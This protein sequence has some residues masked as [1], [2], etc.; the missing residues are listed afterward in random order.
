MCAVSA[1]VL[2]Q[3][4]FESPSSFAT[5]GDKRFR[6]VGDGGNGLKNSSGLTNSSGGVHSA[7]I[8]LRQLPFLLGISLNR[9]WMNRFVHS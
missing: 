4:F 5:L 7:M 6:F 8:D 2:G 9:E 3:S 1:V